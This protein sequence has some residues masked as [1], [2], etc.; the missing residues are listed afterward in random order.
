MP[1]TMLEMRLHGAI[2]AGPMRSDRAVT[3]RATQLSLRVAG[4]RLVYRD[5]VPS[6]VG[7]KLAIFDH[8]VRMARAGGALQV[9]ERAL[10]ASG[11]F[12]ADAPRAWASGCTSGKVH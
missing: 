10:T 7:P 2:R 11:G 8:G 1:D 9:W 12:Q 6:L 4:E 5:G 3:F